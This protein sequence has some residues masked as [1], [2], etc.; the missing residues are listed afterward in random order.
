M[1]SDRW[2]PSPYAIFLHANVSWDFG[3][4]R[5]VLASPTFHRWHHSSEPVAVDKN[6]A[7]FL[8]LWDLLFGTLYLPAG[9]RAM[10]FGM[11]GAKLPTTF[12][13]LMTYPFRERPMQMAS[14][15]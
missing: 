3:P 1:G 14:A 4:V 13:G 15:A 5:L 9:A 7:G 8:P 11:H 12:V 6:F 10:H 2:R